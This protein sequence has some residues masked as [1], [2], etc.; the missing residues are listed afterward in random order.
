MAQSSLPALPQAQHQHCGLV[1][2]YEGEM[3]AAVQAGTNSCEWRDG[4]G[5]PLTCAL[6]CDLTYFPQKKTRFATRK[7]LRMYSYLT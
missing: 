2:G 1:N 7:R 4:P 6:N 3:T 5:L